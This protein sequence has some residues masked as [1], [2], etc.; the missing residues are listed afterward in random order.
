[1]ADQVLKDSK[2]VVELEKSMPAKLGEDSSSNLK[3]A[4]IEA[5]LFSVAKPMSLEDLADIFEVSQETM[6][7]AVETYDK[8]LEAFDRGLRIRKSGAGIEL[9]TAPDCG[10]YLQKV[11]RKEDKLSSAALETLAVVAFKQPVTKSEV[12]ELRGVNCEKVLKQLL[13]RSLITELGHKDTVGRPTLYGTTDEFLRSVGIDSIDDLQASL[14][15]E[16]AIGSGPQAYPGDQP[17][18]EG[19]ILSSEEGLASPIDTVDKAKND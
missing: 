8:E 9:V 13:S 15:V 7:Q 5:V 16:Y 18:F 6:A 17:L 3:S 4:Y 14:E 11:R 1:M 19:D 12:E 2:Q 10:T